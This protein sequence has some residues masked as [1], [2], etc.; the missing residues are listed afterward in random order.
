MIRLIAGG[1][2]RIERIVTAQLPLENVV[3]DGFDRLIDR[4]GPGEGAGLGSVMRRVAPQR[5]V[6][7]SRGAGSGR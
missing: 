5:T 3:T 4:P 7:D 2:Y 1:R 6:G